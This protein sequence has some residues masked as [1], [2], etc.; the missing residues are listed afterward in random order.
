MWALVGA[1]EKGVG[2]GVGDPVEGA[3]CGEE[4]GCWIEDL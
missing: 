1:G 2:V 4:G 3:V